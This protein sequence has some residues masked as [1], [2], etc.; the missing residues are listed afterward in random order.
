[1]VDPEATADALLLLLQGTFIAAALRGDP[2][3]S[4]EQLVR[5]IR[6]VLG[7]SPRG[8]RRK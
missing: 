3:E 1:M 2:R 5:A 6:L 7:L 8:R 4:R